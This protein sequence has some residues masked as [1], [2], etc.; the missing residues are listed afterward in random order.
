MEKYDLCRKKTVIIGSKNKKNIHDL[1]IL[2]NNDNKTAFQIIQNG[3]QCLDNI[4]SLEPDLIILDLSM[5]GKDGLWV[6]ERLKDKKYTKSGIIFI[7]PLDCDSIQNDVAELG[8]N[9][10][11]KSPLDMDVMKIIVSDMLKDENLVYR[12]Y[13]KSGK[14]IPFRIANILNRLGILPGV[15]GYYYLKT[16]IMEV[17]E[18]CEK[19][20]GV[21]KKLYPYIAEKYGTNA[22]K[23]ERAIRHAID[24]S[25]LK[26]PKGYKEVFGFDFLKKPTNRQIISQ[27]AEYIKNKD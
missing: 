23:V 26:E 2:L 19:A 9:K 22:G 17:Y 24:V 10:Y 18:D 27:I 13:S 4:V 12:N 5:S 16:A 3:E 11:V 1:K 8:A 7:S 20:D 14:S 25:W 21:T 15:K 6:L